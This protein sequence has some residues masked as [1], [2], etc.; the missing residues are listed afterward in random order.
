VAVYSPQVAPLSPPA[1]SPER[2]HF[3]ELERLM[4]VDK[5]QALE[6]LERSDAQLPQTGRFAEARQA[7]RITLLVGQGRMREA[8]EHTYKF[9]AEHPQSEYRHLV[10]GQTGIHPRPGAPPGYTSPK[11]P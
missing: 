1:E 8:R 4:V 9:L 2:A 11:E 10:S 3:R 5:A 6:W 7:T